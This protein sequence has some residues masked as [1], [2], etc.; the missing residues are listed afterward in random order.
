MKEYKEFLEN[1]KEEIAEIIKEFN[2]N[3]D[4]LTDDLLTARIEQIVQNAKEKGFNTDRIRM[5]P[6][7][8]F[9]LVSIKSLSNKSKENFLK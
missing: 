7:S 4:P 5:I 1:N 3:N 2:K 8:F 6:S 9:S